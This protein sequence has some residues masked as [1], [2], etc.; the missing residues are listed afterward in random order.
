MGRLLIVDDEKDVHYSFRRMLRRETELE[1]LSAYSAEE[2]LTLL[3]HDSAVDMVIMDIRM[4]GLSG[5]EALE[6]IQGQDIRN[7]PLVI[8]MTAYSTADAAIEATKLGAFDYV[9]KP[10]NVDKMLSLIQEALHARQAM[11]R[12]VTLA[13]DEDRE[14]DSDRIVGTHPS[15]QSVYKMIGRVASTDAT[16]LIQ[17]ES[18]TGKELVARAIYHHSN[19]RERMFLP[20]NCAAI[21]ENLLES[22]L[23]GHERGAFTGA[24]DRRLGKFEQCNRGTLFL[25][26]IGDISFSLQGKIL[27]LLEDGRFQRLGGS[28]WIETDVRILA[29]THRDLER[30]VE[31]GKFREDLYY[32]LNVVSIAIPALRD[33]KEDIPELVQFFIRKYSSRYGRGR[34]G[35]H[36]D[37]IAKLMEYPWPGNVRQLENA[38]K[39]AM[40]ISRG[41]MLLPDDFLLREPASTEKKDHEKLETL[42]PNVPSAERLETLL[43]ELFQELAASPPPEGMLPVIESSLVEKALRFTQGNQVQASRLLGLSRNTLRARMKERGLMKEG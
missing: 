8:M 38:V 19:R 42:K 25:D 33:R 3:A 28:T 39:R 43:K 23:F 41:D 26:E 30:M 24:V 37:A 2:A 5:L 9:M 7:K 20:L 16:I 6:Q 1:V 27:R 15:M 12:V 32:R 4:G 31:Q 29:A 11:Q 18:G 17:G 10:F 40:V 36:S 21:P 14:E 22:E 13:S 34:K 35:L